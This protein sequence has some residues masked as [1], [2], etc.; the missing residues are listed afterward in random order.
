LRDLYLQIHE[1]LRMQEQ[2]GAIAR[3]ETVR[4]TQGDATPDARDPSRAFDYRATWQVDG[5]VE[6][7]GHIHRRTNE[8]EATFRIEAIDGTWKIS[9]LELANQTRVNFETSLRRTQP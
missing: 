9:G 3:V 2:G 8:Y 5:T 4:E 7:W 6:H 1:G